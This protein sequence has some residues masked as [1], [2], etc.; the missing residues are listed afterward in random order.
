M[1][2]LFIILKFIVWDYCSMI[3]LIGCYSP[4]VLLYHCKVY[5]WRPLYN[6]WLF[7][8]VLDDTQSLGIDPRHL[9][10]LLNEAEGFYQIGPKLKCKEQFILSVTI[11]QASN[12]TQVRSLD[13]WS[14][15]SLRFSICW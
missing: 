6:D 12:L 15:L 5:C 3:R 8:V 14:S 9:Q 13:H 1:V 11:A 2:L 4:L 7:V 10:P